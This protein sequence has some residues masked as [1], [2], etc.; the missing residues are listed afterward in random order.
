[1]YDWPGNIRELRNI[2]ERSVA[3]S[4]GPEV[5]VRD[6]PEV[7]RFG[8]PAPGPAVHTSEGTTISVP[9]TLTQSRERAEVQRIIAALCKHE[10]HRLRAAAELGISRMGLYKKLRKYGLLNTA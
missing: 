7:I 5:H 1:N 3:L 8:R 6:L 4:P 9:F 10:N 2:V